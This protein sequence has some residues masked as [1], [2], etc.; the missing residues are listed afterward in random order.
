M[1]NLLKPSRAVTRV[2]CVVCE[3]K[4]KAS[5]RDTKYCTS[6]CR[7]RAARARAS[8]SDIDREIAAARLAYWSAI[9]RKAESE[10]VTKSQVV[11]AQA[12]FVGENGDV[13]MGGGAMGGMGEGR[14]LV[15]RST[16]NR[17]GWAAWGLEAAGPPFSAPPVGGR[18]AK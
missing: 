17:P 5:R 14:R 10:G 6:A 16:A 8:I 9:R 2:K 13:Y 7:Q 11:T 18:G 4:F 3:K 12:Q 1:S 15:G